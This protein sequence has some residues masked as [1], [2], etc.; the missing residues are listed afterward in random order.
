MCA[1]YAVVQYEVHT[2]Q[3][4]RWTL[5]ARFPGGERQEAIRD[6][7]ATEDMTRRHCRV[8]KAT[9]YPQDN[10]SDE[11]TVWVSPRLKELQAK[12]K[13]P[14]TRADAP[15][16][17]PSAVPA[18]A[19]RMERRPAKA[20]NS[21]NLDLVWRTAIAMGMSLIAASIVTAMVSWII[22]KLPAFGVMP[23]PTRVS[24]ILTLTY[25]GV[26]LLGVMSFFRFG[27][28]VK[29]M[30]LR[31]WA[32]AKPAPSEAVIT[33]QQMQGKIKPK[34]PATIPFERER[35][36]AEVKRQR[37]DLDVVADDAEPDMQTA[38]SATEPAAP[39]DAAPPVAAPTSTQAPPADAMPLPPSLEPQATPAP[40]PAAADAAAPF[41]PT[42]VGPP[43]V[44]SELERG[45]AMRFIAEVM[46][47]Q[48]ARLPDD[49]VARRGAALFITGAIRQLASVAGMSLAAEVELATLALGAGLPRHAVDAFFSQYNS[50]VQAAQNQ[51]M[52]DAGRR[53]M[54]NFVGGQP[55]EPPLAQCL[56]IWRVPAL[57]PMTPPVTETA[58][59]A[60][61][62]IYLMTE[63]RGEDAGVMDVHNRVVRTQ[64]EAA[65]GHEIKHT[66]R[67]I[68][69][70]F[71]SA[72]Q[73]IEAAFALMENLH[74][75]RPN[76]Q[77]APC[78]VALVGGYGTADDPLLSSNVTNQ[79]NAMLTAVA[80]GNI[81]CKLS[82]YQAAGALPGLA[83]QR[84]AGGDLLLSLNPAQTGLLT[85]A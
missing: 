48:I 25:G 12:V 3:D 34:R 60:P 50:H 10:S 22:S 26:F 6:A 68:L 83:S 44:I 37:G 9:Y 17:T 11:V 64:L 67:G 55:V 54:A 4:N 32:S 56:S 84:T 31:L 36:M 42:P 27:A 28:P 23:D 29:H 2:W 5:Q 18:A 73:A 24:G 58:G 35:E 74:R 47:A 39:A 70:C 52:I 45:M 65:D 66:G 30:I 77:V 38:V 71:S 57:Q 8:V 14:L 41:A 80:M 78:V 69:A 85:V 72:T 13:R 20:A 63:V 15:L 79:A 7:M 51:V 19:P 82:V 1:L 59:Q 75:A 61:S 49:P 53:A 21:L 62:E 76:A 81:V 33:P 46:A 43:I 40:T 16:R